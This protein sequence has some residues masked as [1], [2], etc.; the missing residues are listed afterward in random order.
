LL[1]REVQQLCTGFFLEVHLNVK[2]VGSDR[3]QGGLGSQDADDNTA[4]LG[5][6]DC[7]NRRRAVRISS[8]ISRTAS[9]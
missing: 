1:I 2:A 4:V 7:F 8:P 9:P 5:E 3:R 6:T